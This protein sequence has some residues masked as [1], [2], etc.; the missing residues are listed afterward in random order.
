[1]SYIETEDNSTF[2]TADLLSDG[3]EIRGQLSTSNDIDVF[4]ISISQPGVISLSFDAPTNSSYTDYFEI[5]LYN[6]SG[7]LIGGQETGQ[8]TS[9]SAGVDQA[10]T[11]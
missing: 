3:Q 7:V 2:G 1:M 8:D 10:G 11:Y 9:F 4:Q 5:G 6:S